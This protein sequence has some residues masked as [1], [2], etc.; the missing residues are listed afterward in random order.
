ME[1]IGSHCDIKSCRQ[2]DFLPFECSHCHGTFCL[3]HRS[4]T[5]HKCAM[6][7]DS[8]ALI[9]ALCNQPVSA[10]PT[11]DPNAAMIVHQDN[12]CQSAE[13]KRRRESRC[14][15]NG[16]KK[17]SLIPFTCSKCRSNFCTTHRIYEDHNCTY[18]E[19]QRTHALATQNFARVLQVK[20]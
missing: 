7:S 18:L 19:R 11:Q 2:L 5:S 16:C 6:P 13:A 4:L 9:C 12:G 10:L 8:R 17:V 1:R 20:S 3:D 14:S 15:F